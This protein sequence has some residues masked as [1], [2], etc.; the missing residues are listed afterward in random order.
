MDAMLQH[1]A[2]A[3]FGD[4]VDLHVD[5][6]LP[7]APLQSPSNFAASGADQSAAPA[8]AEGASNQPA[9]PA[10]RGL[11]DRERRSLWA[12]VGR[13]ENFWCSLEEIEPGS[14]ARLNRLVV[15]HGWEVIF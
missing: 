15:E 6:S 4:D 11:T 13:V 7:L 8:P 14:V 5:P 2:E 12:H 1:H 9:E 10:K 3:L